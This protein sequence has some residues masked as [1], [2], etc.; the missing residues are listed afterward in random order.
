MVTEAKPLIEYVF[1]GRLQLSDERKAKLVEFI[2]REFSDHGGRIFLTK[3]S[4]L[5]V[6]KN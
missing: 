1:S 6:A 3:D 5:F 2:E 4:G